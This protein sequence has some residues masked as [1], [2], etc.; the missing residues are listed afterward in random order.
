MYF[1]EENDHDV[2]EEVEF[3][4]LS[5]DDIKQ[6]S[7]VEIKSHETF[8]GSNPV[9]EWEFTIYDEFWDIDGSERTAYIEGDADL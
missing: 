8:C 7:V 3:G 2:L 5:T 4:I 1:N 6:F 9:L